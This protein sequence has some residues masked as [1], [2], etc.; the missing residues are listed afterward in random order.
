[1]SDAANELEGKLH[2]LSRTDYE[3]QRTALA[4][5][6]CVRATALDAIYKGL[7][8]GQPRICRF[9]ATSATAPC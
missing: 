3:L 9:P 7:H 4:K 8:L 2:D 5:N 6:A 1:M